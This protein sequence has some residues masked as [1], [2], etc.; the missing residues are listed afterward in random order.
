MAEG[1]GEVVGGAGSTMIGCG[2]GGR[3]SILHKVLDG[4]KFTVHGASGSLVL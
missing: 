3:E 4:G 1:C 2:G